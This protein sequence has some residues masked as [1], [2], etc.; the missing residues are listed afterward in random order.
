M[1]S[2]SNSSL[3][4]LPRTIPLVEIAKKR[5]F[6]RKG[7]LWDDYRGRCWYFCIFA[8]GDVKILTWFP[9]YANAGQSRNEEIKK[10]SPLM[11]VPLASKDRGG[12]KYREIARLPEFEALKMSA[13]GSLYRHEKKNK[14]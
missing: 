14:K 8:A 2:R 6:S 7:I 11:G 10:T 4:F 12:L 13:L 5:Y 9:K 3:K 1:W